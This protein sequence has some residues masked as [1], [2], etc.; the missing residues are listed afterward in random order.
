LKKLRNIASIQS[1]Q[2]CPLLRKQ[3]GQVY[4]TG[5]QKRKTAEILK[6]LRNKQHSSESV[7]FRKKRKV[8]MPAH[9]PIMMPVAFTAGG[10]GVAASESP[11]R[12]FKFQVPTR[13]PRLHCDIEK[14]PGRFS[15]D[16]PGPCMTPSRSTFFPVEPRAAGRCQ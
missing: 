1:S 10:L 8:L 15:A 9:G 6:K 16:P 2:F 11:G 13:S 3:C 12:A 14:S 4:K 7:A 5:R